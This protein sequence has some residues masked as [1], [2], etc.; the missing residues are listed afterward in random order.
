MC[1]SLLGITEIKNNPPELELLDNK[2]F[3]VSLFYGAQI[4]KII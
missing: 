3:I 4:I 1:S 2:C